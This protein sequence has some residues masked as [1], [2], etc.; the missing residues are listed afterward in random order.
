MPVIS[1][2]WLF[3]FE[4][5]LKLDGVLCCGEEKLGV[6]IRRFC[7]FFSFTSCE[8]KPRLL[9]ILSFSVVSPP[10]SS[11]IFFFLLYLF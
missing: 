1:P 4:G 7:I 5:I 8:M 3:L 6:K 2:A 10:F 11:F 9:H